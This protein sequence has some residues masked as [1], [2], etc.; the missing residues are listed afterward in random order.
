M[1]DRHNAGMEIQEFWR[2]VETAREDSGV[3]VGLFDEATVAEALVVRLAVLPP[4]EI[5][6]FDDLLGDVIGRLDTRGVALACRIITGFLS[7]DLFSSFRAGLVGLGRRAVEQILADPDSLADHPAVI[8][9]AEGRSERMS[10]DSEDLLFAASSAYA[11]ISDGDDEAFWHAADARDRALGSGDVPRPEGESGD[12][13]SCS[14]F[15][16]RLSA[17]LPPERWARNRNRNR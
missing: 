6:D 8:D 1:Q 5:L 3:T 12:A 14:P 15:L 13:E 2:I 10:L 16:P 4:G 11:R 17:L 7:D 9:I